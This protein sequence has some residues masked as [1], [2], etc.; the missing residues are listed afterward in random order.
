MYKLLKDKN[1]YGNFEN[2]LVNTRLL[3]LYNNNRNLMESSL[4]GNFNHWGT[5]NIFRKKTSSSNTLFNLKLL[6]LS[7]FKYFNKNYPV[8]ILLY[9]LPIL[10]LVYTI[11]NVNNLNNIYNFSLFL[12]SIVI[13][14]ISTYV[15]QLVRNYY[16]L[17]RI[18]NHNIISSKLINFFKI[19]TDD[20][21][22]GI[23]PV[24]LEIITTDGETNT[25]TN[26]ELMNI[27]IQNHVQHNGYN[28]HNLMTTHKNVPI[29]TINTVLRSFMDSYRNYIH[30][31]E[32]TDLIGYISN[33]L[34][35][36]LIH[37]HI[38]SYKVIKETPTTSSV[39]LPQSDVLVRDLLNT[40][41]S[42]KDGKTSYEPLQEDINDYYK[43]NG[44]VR[45]F[46]DNLHLKMKT[47]GIHEH[48]KD[49][50]FNEIQSLEQAVI[51]LQEVDKDKKHSLVLKSTLNELD[52]VKSYCA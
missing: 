14:L 17:R 40:F 42:N 3:T 9:M 34:D 27:L 12:A 49:E 19:N 35:Y 44:K 5:E 10:L 33:Y 45:T 18:L 52:K 11:Y 51:E 28:L 6:R 25:I 7:S 8:L 47:E 32:D 22:K 23:P 39:E 20:I 41:I 21:Y 38:M 31:E 4:K 15:I 2:R 46:R 36:L 26:I 48:N 50:I 29:V 30:D 16:N 24:N 37:H 1:I 13:V 43:I